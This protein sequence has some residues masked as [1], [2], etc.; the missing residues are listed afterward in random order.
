MK[1]VSIVGARPQFIKA[2]AFSRELRRRHQEVL[3]HT[4]QHYDY[5][6]SGTFF[7]GLEIPAPEVNLG[8][9][10][11]S[12]GTQTGA[13]LGKIEEVLVS[14]DPQWVVVYGDT[15]STL[16]GA[17][18]ASK[19]HIPVAH[20][21]A[22]LR[23]FNRRMPEEI[24]RVLTDH[25]SDLLLC[26]SQTAIRNLAGEGIARNVH[27]VGDIMLD[28]LNWA[29]DRIKAQLPTILRQLQ[30]GERSYVLVTVHRSENTDDETRLVDILR[31]LNDLNKP[32]I[33][34]IHPR[35]RK[36]LSKGGYEL[37]PHVRLIDPVSYLDMVT[38]TGSAQLVL[39]DSGGLQKEAY[40]LGVPCLTL[41]EETEW[42]ETTKAGWNALVGTDHEKIVHLANTFIPP[43]E[44]PP[45]YGDGC[46]A[47]RC[48]DLLEPPDSTFRAAAAGIAS[49]KIQA[50]FSETSV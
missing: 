37:F 15:N 7:D 12:H 1:V 11:G 36:A 16:A 19:L 8:I 42:V 13:M 47:A 49:I 39:T 18:A 40:W 28:V 31:A 44:R 29:R 23:S 50:G 6:M 17:L 30:L 20:V 10:S 34:P 21:E 35:T 48:V 38:L 9:G 14:E 22:G 2:A 4:G 46:V 27:L 33:F 24:N 26:P 32:V 5:A 43:S 25:I 3:V 45:L 41:R